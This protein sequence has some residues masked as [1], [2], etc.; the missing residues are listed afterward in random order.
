MEILDAFAIDVHW[1]ELLTMGNLPVS[2]GEEVDEEAE[3]EARRVCDIGRAL[4]APRAALTFYECG[5]ISA[6]SGTVELLPRDGGRPEALHIGP[7]VGYLAPARL[8]AVSIATIGEELERRMRKLSVEGD[9]M[10]AY[11]LDLYGTK[12]M[13]KVNAANRAHIEAF[14]GE[15]GWGVGP[16]MKPG[17]AEGWGIQGQRDLLRL[18]GAE[19]IGV[20]IK[21]SFL[22]VPYF[23]GSY[24]IG[25]GPDY[26]GKRAGFLCHECAKFDTC[27]WRREN[28]AA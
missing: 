14:A 6:D 10:T 15:K 7:K 21:P 3:E 19:R 12:A 25:I 5:E 8:V 4:L 27:L 18:S 9:V 2:E 17:S 20:S 11:Y 16:V 1:S 24:V 26:Q 23:S 22:L 13:N 28:S